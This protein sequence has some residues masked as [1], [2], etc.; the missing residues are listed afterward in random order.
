MGSLAWQ[1]S[2]GAD[3]PVEFS[4]SG[5]TCGLPQL[6]SNGEAIAYEVIN[7]V[8]YGYVPCEKPSDIGDAVQALKTEGPS[9]P[10]EGRLVFTL[11]LQADG[12][13]R[14][15]L[16]DQ[17]DHSGCGEDTMCIDFSSM[18]VATD[19]DGDSITLDGND[20]IIQIIDDMPVAN[21]V[22]VVLDDDDVIGANGNPGGPN[23]DIGP[24]YAIATGTLNFSYGAD[25]PGQVDFA[26]MDGKTGMVGIEE[27]TYSWDGNSNTLTATGPRG[28]LFT[29][30]VT[31]PVTG[32]Y[33]VTQV[34]N[35]L[36]TPP[37]ITVNTANYPAI[38]DLV[39]ITVGVT[40]GDLDDVVIGHQGAALLE[41]G[42]GFG[43]SSK[44]DNNSY[45]PDEINH[46][47]P[48]WDHESEVMI[49][50][51]QGDG[52][53]THATVDIN[54]FYIREGGV[55]NEQ[56][57]YALYKD[58]VQVQGPTN[59]TANN[60]SG[61]FTLNIECLAGFDEI[62]FGAVRGTSDSYWGD[63]SDYYINEIT[64][65]DIT[66]ENNTLV[67]LTYTA[68]DYDGDHDH[69]T[70]TLNLDDDTPIAV[71]DCVA[72]KAGEAT[73][74]TYNLML[75][76]DTSG[77][78]SDSQ[79]HQEV[80]AMKALL[81]KYA[82]IAEGGA[83][84]VRVQIVSFASG[85][86]L[87]SA[88][89]ETIAVAIAH[90]DA[91]A[92]AGSG[93][94]T[95]YDAA[96]A[97]AT[98]GMAAWTTATADHENVV[99][100]VS[101]GEPNDG[102]I[103]DGEENAWEDTLDGVGATAWA[104]GV[105]ASASDPD[106]AD[107]AYPDSQVVR[108]DDFDDL[109]DGLIGTITPETVTGNVMTNDLPGA[110]GAEVT[111]VSYIDA[112]GKAAT[113]IVDDDGVT[114]QTQL[115]EL[116]IESDGDYSYKSNPIELVDQQVTVNLGNTDLSS[117]IGASGMVKVSVVGD[118]TTSLIENEGAFG[119]AS[120]DGGDGGRFDEI[121]YL[122]G[123]KSEAMIFELQ[124]GKVAGSALV[125]ITEFYK[126]E[127]GVGNEVGSYELYLDGVKVQDAT[128]FTA[129]SKGGDLQL[130]IDGPDCGFDEIR[131]MANE[132]TLPTGKD[133]SDYSIKSV[134]FDLNQQ[135]V[136]HYEITDGDGDKSC[137]D[138][139]ININVDT[140]I[141][142]PTHEPT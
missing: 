90:L 21:D 83:D 6:T 86:T 24:E 121:N 53:A 35:V 119:V 100:F 72:T 63:T 115:G 135:D 32:D 57:V 4:M 141:D 66:G 97:Q 37:E 68:T 117:G 129:N 47:D 70:L 76:L 60:S 20:F 71:D 107:I 19:F 62:R 61:D 29:V 108:V 51:L 136:F 25:G 102:V 126:D 26:S 15:I 73:G 55:G 3:E 40:H 95:N 130:L 5:D 7:G 59:F 85:A 125:D 65:T 139:T 10:V 36:H 134:T 81:T 127:S 43:I 114:V 87:D 94:M 132:G 28:T 54:S 123:G 58:G 104:I 124:D 122:G 111:A 18:I 31:N 82:S 34:D 41:T 46:I 79:I 113:A 23:D 8:L 133:N 14:F 42:Y 88:T 45:G 49:F 93:G 9:I 38:D 131:F 101:D 103:D 120:N 33:K 13:Y 91:I 98:T 137:A 16:H 67:D 99:Y 69:G 84:G 75:I 77:S 52:I 118:G 116:F 22:A 110:D 11:E 128:L 140:L 105:G 64:F 12:D 17:L 74:K 138:L 142:D 78:M 106:L 56:G 50:S 96:V 30:E 89:P 1:V 80:D 48:D 2:V 109:L 27:V 92:A 112:D 44:V 39:K